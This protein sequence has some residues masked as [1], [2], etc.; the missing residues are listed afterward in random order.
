[1]SGVLPDWMIRRAVKCGSITIVPFNDDHIQPAS[2]DVT[3]GD[4]ILI[5]RQPLTSGDVATHTTG[6]PGTWTPYI[7]SRDGEAI[8]MP[9][10]AFAL[11]DTA[12]IIGLDEW[13][14]ARLQGRSS[15][16]RL[17]L[18]I[19]CAGFVDPGFNGTLTLELFNT[20]PWPVR[21]IKGMPIGQLSFESLAERAH[22]PYNGK[23]QNQIGP[24]PTRR[25]R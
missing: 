7:F 11:A 22:T 25:P 5:A 13:H 19:E 4:R 16:G 18:Q 17:G 9:S 21:L 1:M 3:L 20:A 8:D 6:D 15:I 23:Y 12:E 10:G 2:Y 14:L 24:T